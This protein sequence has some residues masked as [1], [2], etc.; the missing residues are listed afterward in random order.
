MRISTLLL[1]VPLP[2]TAAC[3][4]EAIRSDDL[5]QLKRQ[6]EPGGNVGRYQL[7]QRGTRT[8]RFDTA[9]GQ[10]CLLLA[11]DSE[12]KDEKTKASACLSS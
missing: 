4:Y 3:G 5:T 6:A 12:W 1:L 7:H 9:T 11:A 10:I 2:L 8:W